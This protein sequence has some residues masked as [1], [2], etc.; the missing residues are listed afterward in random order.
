MT[1]ENFHYSLSCRIPDLMVVACLR[2]IA[3]ECQ[4]GG[5]GP[6]N[7]SSS[8]TGEEIWSAN[9]Q[10]KFFFTTSHRRLAFLNEAERL[11]GGRWTL[12]A[13]SDNDPAQRAPSRPG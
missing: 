1:H 6:P 12:L 11:L 2:A 4:K 5:G 10:V 8:G 7:I 9:Q 3:Y 13:M